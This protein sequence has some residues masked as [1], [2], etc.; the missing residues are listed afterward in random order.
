[1]AI[2]CLGAQIL[3]HTLRGMSGIIFGSEQIFPY[4][5]PE[6]LDMINIK[7]QHMLEFGT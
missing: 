3:N 2:S 1:M 7:K 4:D 6:I 5:D